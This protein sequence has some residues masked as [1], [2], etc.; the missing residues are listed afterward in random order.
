MAQP[1]LYLVIFQKHKIYSGT[2]VLIRIQPTFL[3][4]LL[5][6]FRDLNCKGVKSSPDFDSVFT[7][8]VCILIMLSAYQSHKLLFLGD[9]P[10]TFLTMCATPS[11]RI[12]NSA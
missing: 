12:L 1:M 9:K 7:G 6:I 4:F 2:G 3:T 11:D 10:L 8:C 5:F